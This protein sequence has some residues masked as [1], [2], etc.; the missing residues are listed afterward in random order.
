MNI[1]QYLTIKQGDAKKNYLPDNTPVVLQSQNKALYD[2]VLNYLDSDCVNQAAEQI[3]NAKALL[4]NNH[5]GTRI[6]IHNLLYAVVYNYL[7]LV[8]PVN[9][10]FQYDAGMC[11]GACGYGTN[12]VVALLGN[13]LIETNI[14]LQDIQRF[15]QQMLVEFW[16]AFKSLTLAQMQGTGIEYN[17]RGKTCP[18][19]LHLTKSKEAFGLVD[20]SEP[21]SQCTDCVNNSDAMFAQNIRI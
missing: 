6:F 12:R 11:K 20:E 14:P 3:Q 19:R 7:G 16:T 4:A 8:L 1:Q 18:V 9:G 2:A 21:A 10:K 17:F 15:P 13:A 5:H